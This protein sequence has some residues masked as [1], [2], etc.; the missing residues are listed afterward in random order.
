MIPLVYFLDPISGDQWRLAAYERSLKVIS[1]QREE[2]A[3]APSGAKQTIWV[4]V[5]G[6]TTSGPSTL[7]IM[8]QETR[9]GANTEPVFHVANR[10]EAVEILRVAV[11]HYLADEKR[12]TAPQGEVT[13]ERIV[14][15]L[16]KLGI[17]HQ[18]RS[19]WQERVHASTK[20][21][22]L[23]DDAAADM[24]RGLNAGD[25]AF[26]WQDATDRVIALANKVREAYGLI[27]DMQRVINGH[28]GIQGQP[29]Y[30]VA[31]R[32]IAARVNAYFSMATPGPTPQE[33][34]NAELVSELS[35]MTAKRD[36]I[37]GEKAD[38]KAKVEKLEIVIRDLSRDPVREQNDRLRARV[39]ELERNIAAMGRSGMSEASAYNAGR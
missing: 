11:R 31:R 4:T 19:D 27:A 39:D 29:G 10:A 5:R 6:M 30:E 34:R 21:R 26:R 18:P 12:A 25:W 35:A 14:D 24:A 9:V 13:N 28:M 38:F 1:L 17:E 16:K 36:R 22:D 32:L 3:V 15:Q 7:G 20:P 37:A 2:L 33:I 8:V 23:C